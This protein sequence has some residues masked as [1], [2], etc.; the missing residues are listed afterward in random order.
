VLGGDRA[1]VGSGRGSGTDIAKV[2]VVVVVVVVDDADRAAGGDR[3]LLELSPV[4]AR[5]LA[6]YRRR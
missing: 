5:S 1:V 6:C 3:V 2:V 4:G